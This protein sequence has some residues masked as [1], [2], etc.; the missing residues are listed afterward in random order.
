[1]PEPADV[2]RP[3][4]EMVTRVDTP[5]RVVLI[6][7][8]DF[9]AVENVDE[10]PSGRDLDLLQSIQKV[11]GLGGIILSEEDIDPADVDEFH[12]R[13]YADGQADRTIEDQPIVSPPG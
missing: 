10:L 1:M 12:A 5:R 11:L 3:P 6:R 4:E 7:P 13:F 2:A 9:L 8:G